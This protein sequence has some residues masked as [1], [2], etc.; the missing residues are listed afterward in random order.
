MSS[1]GPLIDRTSY[2]VHG[3]K[4]MTYTDS[5]S[6]DHKTSLKGLWRLKTPLEP[7]EVG[8]GGN[9]L[10][11]VQSDVFSVMLLRKTVID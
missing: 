3:H 10:L 2:R 1:L 4:R 5:T 8:R 6:V 11:F 9:H 7:Q